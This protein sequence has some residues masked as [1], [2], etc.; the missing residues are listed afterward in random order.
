[1][2]FKIL[3]VFLSF[4]IILTALSGCREEEVPVPKDYPVKVAG[5]TVSAQPK[6]VA[7]L[8]EAVA[9]GICALGYGDYLKGAVSEYIEHTESSVVDLGSAYMPDW[10]KV[11]ALSPDVLLTPEDVDEDVKEALALRDITT[12][13]LKTPTSLGE[14]ATFYEELAKLF[15]GAEDYAQTSDLFNGEMNRMIEEF[16]I[17]NT[18]GDKK[19]AVFLEEDLALTGDTLGGEIL[20]TVGINNIAKE[21]SGKIMTVQ[22]IAEANPEIVFCPV[23]SSQS[24]IDNENYKEVDAIKNG[25]VYEV[26]TVAIAFAGEGFIITMQEMLNYINM[27]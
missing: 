17:A 4:L 10:E 25:R 27:Q 18:S 15:I 24:F 11:Y 3:T 14:V 16:K 13:T 12:V 19:I 5:V 20:R 8:S 22:E 21:Y 6:S 9:S 23:G 2:K 1:M 7:A 26:D